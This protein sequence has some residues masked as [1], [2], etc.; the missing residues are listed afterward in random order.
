MQ[1]SSYPQ[2]PGLCSYTLYAILI[3]PSDT[4]PVFLHPLC[5]THHTL[6]YLACVPTPSIQ[7]SSYPQIPGLCSYTLYT[8]L[9]IPSDTWPLFL[10]PLYNTHHTLR[11]LASVPAHTH[12][13]T[14]HPI[15]R[16]G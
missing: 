10:H 12:K 13:H 6:R 3:I 11:Y 9:I 5:N 4:W 2:I 1:Y 8:I 15:A 7:Y 14:A 16:L